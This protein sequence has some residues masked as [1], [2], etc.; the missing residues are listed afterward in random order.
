MDS[1]AQVLRHERDLLETLLFRLDEAALVAAADGARWW[2][3]AAYDVDAAATTVR[4][5]ELLR[6]VTAVDAALE[7]GLEPEATLRALAAA[8][9][10]PDRSVL[11][12]HREAIRTLSAE[13]AGAMQR[14]RFAA[15][16]PHVPPEARRQGIGCELPGL[17]AFLR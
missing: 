16:G 2:V 17:E 8:A 5:T 10:Q 13:I 11:L 4:R 7:L 14:L 15:S 6:A 3:R 12:D 1:L 9:D